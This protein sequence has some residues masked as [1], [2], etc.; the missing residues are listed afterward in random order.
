MLR[1]DRRSLVLHAA[2]IPTYG[3]QPSVSW[4]FLNRPDEPDRGGLYDAFG[5]TYLADSVDYVCGFDA[6]GWTHMVTTAPT[7][8]GRRRMRPAEPDPPTHPRSTHPHPSPSRRPPMLPT[9]THHNTTVTRSAAS[10]AD[11]A[12][13]TAGIRVAVHQLVHRR[14]VTGAVANDALAALGIAPL[15]DRFVVG[16]RLPATVTA[17]TPARAQRTAA[18]LIVAAVRR[19]RVGYLRTHSVRLS[20]LD[21]PPPNR[22]PQTGSSTSPATRGYRPSRCTPSRPRS[23][24][25]SPS[26]PPTT[27]APG[28]PP[29]GSS[30]P[31]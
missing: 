31:R 22:S 10:G 14:V 26:P 6:I 20:R 19:L 28:S 8:A 7:R 25:V 17:H 13:V 24:S 16:M 5:V 11:D 12:A 3:W 23:C 21:V 1:A 29:T 18:G 15:R 9:H 4:V 30:A 27:T 2:R